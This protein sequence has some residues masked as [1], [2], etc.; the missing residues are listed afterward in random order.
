[1]ADVVEQNGDL[2][3]VFLIPGNFVTFG[4]EHLD[5]LVHQVHGA[6]GVMKARMQ[7]P[8]INQVR[9]SQLFYPPEPLEIPVLDQI[10]NQVILNRDKPVNR[11]VQDFFLIPVVCVHYFYDKILKFIFPPQF[12]NLPATAAILL[13][14]C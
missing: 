6:D 10:E 2:R 12:S 7:R 9:Q 5:G 13:L 3:S 8:G 11:V 4:A 14:L 1:M